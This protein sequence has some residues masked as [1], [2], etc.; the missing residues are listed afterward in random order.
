MRC[1]TGF[2]AVFA[3]LMV[4]GTV[5]AQAGPGPGPGP[6]M[7]MGNGPMMF[8]AANTPGWALMTPEEQKA[9]RGKMNSMTTLS[10]CKA[11]MAQHHQEMLERAKAKGVELRGPNEFACDRLKSMGR[12]K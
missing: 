10:E 12:L 1:V 7:G 5:H 9:H 4:C 2:L 3:A 11:Y 8:G 6:G